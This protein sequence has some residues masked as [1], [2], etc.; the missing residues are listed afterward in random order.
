MTGALAVVEAWLD[1]V[2]RADV[3]AA[4]A[5]SAPDL[6]VAGPRGSV[7]GREV[8]GPWTAR[9]GL[10][11]RPLRWFC[12]AGGAGGPVAVVVEQDATWTDPDTGAE[13]G[14]AVVAS[15]FTVDGGVVTTVER[16]DAGL[17]A[18]L[19]AAGLGPADEVAVRR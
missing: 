9:A 14:R 5:L 2:D 1:A 7:R 3:E 12:G 4:T 11:T 17:P 8:L 18:A 10:T 6:E 13:R 19:A 15:R 16:H